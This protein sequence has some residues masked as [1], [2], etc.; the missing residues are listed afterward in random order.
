[1]KHLS[2]VE[3]T[4][5]NLSSLDSLHAGLRSDPRAES[6]EVV[7]RIVMRTNGTPV[8]VSVSRACFIE[9]RMMSN[10]QQEASAMAVHV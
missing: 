7:G 8:A 10:K 1:M 4:V 3:G 9:A 5:R 2:R 6:R